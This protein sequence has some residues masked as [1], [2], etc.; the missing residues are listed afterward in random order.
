[1]LVALINDMLDIS[2]LEADRT[3]FKLNKLDLIPFLKQ[4]VQDYQVMCRNKKIKLSLTYPKN[5]KL[6]LKTDPDKL[7]VVFNNLI[8]NAYKFTPPNGQDPQKI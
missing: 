2:R 6:A 5:L 3:E 7:R 1:M 8:S 4:L